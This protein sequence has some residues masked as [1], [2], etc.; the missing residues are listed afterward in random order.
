MYMHPWVPGSAVGMTGAG[1]NWQIRLF[2]SGTSWQPPPQTV[3]SRPETTPLVFL[4]GTLTK[5]GAARTKSPNPGLSSDIGS[6]TFHL[7]SDS[8]LPGDSM[9]LSTEIPGP[10]PPGP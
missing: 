5:V 9:N 10:T 4:K 6:E 8:P 3:K 7:R 1:A 2:R